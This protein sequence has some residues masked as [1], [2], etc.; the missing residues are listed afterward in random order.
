MPLDESTFLSDLREAKPDPCGGS[1]S[2]FALADGLMELAAKDVT[3]RRTEI[4]SRR[5]RRTTPG[6]SGKPETEVEAQRGYR[7][8]N[9]GSRYAAGYRHCLVEQYCHDFCI[10]QP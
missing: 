4:T 8:L 1:A 7:K 10:G 2:A 6:I 5:S 3:D 9:R